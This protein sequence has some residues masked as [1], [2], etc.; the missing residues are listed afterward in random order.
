MRQRLSTLAVAVLAMVLATTVIATSASAA[1][2]PGNYKGKTKQDYNFKFKAKALGVK[3]FKL[4]IEAP[5]DDGTIQLF[6][7]TGAQ[8]PTDSAGKFVA[9]FVGSTGTVT[10][11]GKLKGKRANGNI[12]V[13]GTNANSSA[14]SAT[15]KWNAK[16]K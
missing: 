1:F 14:C 9:Q 16:K 10:V 6:E 13:A 15:T 4:K 8:A 7:A 12:D 3:N 2:K 11:N 5:C